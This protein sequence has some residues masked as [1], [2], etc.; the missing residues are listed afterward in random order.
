MKY[1]LIARHRTVWPVRVMCRVK[2]VLASG[3]YNWA[4]RAPNQRSQINVRLTIRIRESFA[5]SDCVYAAR[6]KYDETCSENRVARLMQA[7]RLKA[8]SKHR[9][10]PGDSGQRPEHSI[11]VDAMV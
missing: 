2:T 6:T 7:A 9:R 5:A 4:I 10:P 3:D 8:H 11:A 1:G